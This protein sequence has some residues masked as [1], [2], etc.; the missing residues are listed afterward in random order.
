MLVLV[1]GLLLGWLLWILLTDGAEQ[2]PTGSAA[3]TAQ[4][5]E[6][7]ASD[8]EPSKAAGSNAAGRTKERGGKAQRKDEQ[9]GNKA[10]RSKKGAR[11]GRELKTVTTTLDAAADS[12]EPASVRVQPAVTG[13]AVAGQQVQLDLMLSTTARAACRLEVTADQLLVQ[14][15][16]A[17]R[18][19]A[20]WDTSRC[21][22]SLPARNLALRPGWQ[23]SLSVPWSGRL[24]DRG[25]TGLTDAAKPGPYA[26][27]A[28]A[29]GGEPGRSGFVLAAA[30]GAVET[31]RGR[32]RDAR[33]RSNEPAAARGQRPQ[34]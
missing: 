33:S 16:A 13:P 20:I 6:P 24:G 8:P 23:T 19:V 25:C 9:A 10:D 14:V 12:C 31:P 21:P 26:V 2:Q 27:Q 22:A 32:A 17:D 11:R 34:T 5:A 1:L 15:S 3:P 7:R 18:P 28:A 30:P 29:V 4:R